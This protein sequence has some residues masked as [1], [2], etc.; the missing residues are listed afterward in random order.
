MDDQWQNSAVIG[1][2]ACV[3]RS[4]ALFL[5]FITCNT[6]TVLTSGG[7]FFCSPVSCLG[8]SSSSALGVSS[9]LVYGVELAGLL[10]DPTFSVGM[11]SRF[12][13]GA[14]DLTYLVQNFVEAGQFIPGAFRGRLLLT[15]PR[16]FESGVYCRALHAFFFIPAFII[17]IA[18]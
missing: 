18:P 17:A 10:E 11:I 9:P 7:N 16:A 12:T 6:F 3:S 5:P 8:G 14:M 2:G 4:A 15:W 1:P 13:G